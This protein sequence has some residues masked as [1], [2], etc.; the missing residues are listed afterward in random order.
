MIKFNNLF[1]RWFWFAAIIALLFF[2]Y[3]SQYVLKDYVG[4]IFISMALGV[5][6]QQYIDGTFLW[7]E[8]TD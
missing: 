4:L 3:E 7:K 2:F 1:F 5:W 6:V 8:E